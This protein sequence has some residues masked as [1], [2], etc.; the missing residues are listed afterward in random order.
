MATLTYGQLNHST[1]DVDPKIQPNLNDYGFIENK[2]QLKSV[3]NATKENIHYYLLQN[4]ISIYLTDQGLIY[5]FQ[6]IQD[7]SD[8]KEVIKHSDLETYQFSMRLKNCQPNPNIKATQPNE[9]VIRFYN[10]AG[11][12]NC[13]HFNKIVYQNVYPGI[14]WVVYVNNHTLKYDFVVQP[15]VDPSVIQLEFENINPEISAE[16]DLIMNTLLGNI[17]EL[18]PVSFQNSTAIETKFFAHNKSTIGFDI[19]SYDKSKKLIIDPSVAWSTYYGGSNDDF[20]RSCSVDGDGNVYLAGYTGSLTTVAVSGHQVTFGGGTYDAF[21]VKFNSAGVRQWSTYYGGLGSD[22]GYSV[23]AENITSGSVYLTGYTSSVMSIATTGSHQT[24]IGG[25]DDAFLVKFNSAGVRQWATYY[26]GT[27]NDYANSVCVDASGFVYI[28]GQ[29][30]STTAIAST[31]SHQATNGGVRDAFLVKFNSAGVRQWGTYVGGASDEYGND[32]FVNS[33]GVYLAGTTSSTT[34]IATTGTFSSALAGGPNDGFVV[35]F[36]SLGVRQW[37]T[38]VGGLG[39]DD[40]YAC[41]A[42]NSDNL[43]ISGVTNSPSGIST[44]GTHQENLNGTMDMYIIKL[45][46]LGQR[47]WGTY[48]GGSLCSSYGRDILIHNNEELYVLG[49]TNCSSLVTSGGGFDNTHGGLND[50]FIALFT[51][52]GLLNYGSYTGGS[53]DDFGYGLAKSGTS[54]L[55][56]CGLTS[57]T[58]AI[59]TSGSHQAAIGGLKDAFLRKIDD[60]V[61]PLTPG[62][63]S[64][65]TSVCEGTTNTYSITP[66]VGAASYTWTLPSGWTGTSTT[67]T[68]AVTVDSN[69]G[70]LSVVANNACGSTSA[71]NLTINILPLPITPGPITGPTS[72]CEGASDSYET[73]PILG[74]TTYYWTLP[75]GW[76]GSTTSPSIYATASA[77]SGTISVTTM[78]SCGTSIPSTL[79]VTVNPAPVVTS[80]DVTICEGSDATLNATADIGTIT[81]YYSPSSGSVAGTGSVLVVSGLTFDSWYYAEAESSAGCVNDPRTEVMVTV[82]PMPDASVTTSFPSITSNEPGANYQWIDCDLM[83]NLTGETSQTFTAAFDGNFAVIIDLAGCIDTSNC[84]NITG[85]NVDEVYAETEILLYPN[86]TSVSCQLSTG[87]SHSKISSLTLISTIGEQVRTLNNINADTTTLDLENLPTGIYLIEVELN[88][89]S[90]KTLKLIKN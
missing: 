31:G 90:K 24:S 77:T 65:T 64:G 13:Q 52:D 73:S 16:N 80:S 74:V 6:K 1:I 15:N 78:N 18:K 36:N 75:S 72:I 5:Q 9:D 19:A 88:N 29:S 32:C 81:W 71:S 51:T 56:Y 67:N 22:I 85:V 4:G 86:P 69:N 55:Y 60:C 44:T 62:A 54:S 57:S 45:N 70:T 46:N 23:T 41:S 48:Y 7:Q 11:E 79:M 50:A 89:A 30:T 20:G 61:L 66:V 2:G 37:G 33:G 3:K 59:S 25:G 47:T 27:G 82:L 76:L 43:Y 39:F 58:A 68:I 84:V 21:L 8:N 38:Y 49:Y 42:D 40:L 83:S 10:E 28:A 34:S 63:I 87:N 26:G 14:D 53:S 17:R 12:F 35:K